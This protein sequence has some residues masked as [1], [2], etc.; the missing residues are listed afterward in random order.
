MTEKGKAKI[1]GY[2]IVAIISGLGIIGW[3]VSDFFGGMILFLVAYSIIIIPIILLYI[4]SFIETTISLIRKGKQT[5]KI[6]LTAH[7]V[8]ILTIVLFNLFNSGTFKSK[9]ILTAI[10]K[11]DLY[12]Y[13]LVFRENGDVENQA[14]GA[15]GFSKTYY[16]KYKI[17]KDLIIFSKK[18]YDNDFIPD[19]LL[20]DKEQNAIFLTKD[21]NGQFSN[22]KEWL[23][24]FELE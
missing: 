23:N 20:L 6:K 18:P 9:R 12:H 2:D 15:F 21:K 4:V 16:G 24:H 11:D 22:K 8:V 13:R 3:I 5:N 10:L 1:T 7:L 19:T 17:E 14:I